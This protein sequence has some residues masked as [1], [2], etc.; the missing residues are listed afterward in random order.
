MTGPRQHSDEAFRR[1]HAEHRPHPEELGL[2][3]LEAVLSTGELKRRPSR[4]PDHE[5]ENRALVRLAQALADSPR[6]VLQTLA[7]IFLEVFKADSAGISLLSKDE[8][9]FFWPAIAG[10]W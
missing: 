1:R 5:T 7:N 4:A 10:L 2:V 3:P 8:K 9:S 6:S